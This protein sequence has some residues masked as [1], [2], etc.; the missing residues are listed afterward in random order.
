M[1]NSNITFDID[2]LTLND[3]LNDSAL[4][5]KSLWNRKQLVRLYEKANGRKMSDILADIMNGKTSPYITSKNFMDGIRKTHSPYTCYMYRSLLTGMFE[6]LLGEGKF[7]KKKL[8]RLVPNGSAYITHVRLS[9]N[10]R[11]LLKCSRL[12]YLSIAR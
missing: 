8:D 7:S 10:A 9:Q 1:D 11:K 4:E 6:S 3:W 2:V 5:P 12:L